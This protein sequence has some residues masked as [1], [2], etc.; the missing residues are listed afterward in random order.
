VDFRAACY[1][2]GLMHG[3][4][5]TGGVASPSDETLMRRVGRGDRDAFVELVRRHQGGVVN[6]FRRMGDS[7]DAEDLAQ[8][9]FLRL[10]RYRK[11]Y[12]PTAK[13]TTFLY[14]LARRTRIDHLRKLERRQRLREAVAGE[15]EIERSVRDGGRALKDRAVEALAE[16]SEEMRSVVVMSVFQGLKYRE[17]AEIMDIPVGT[18]KTRMFHAVRRLREVLNDA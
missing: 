2:V 14:L 9:T 3:N 16:L 12:R 8:E 17:I 4:D 6:F 15:A 7:K 13:L 1:G 5:E 11:Q 18:V 10:F